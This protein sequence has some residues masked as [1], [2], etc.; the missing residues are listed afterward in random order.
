MFWDRSAQNEVNVD[1]QQDHERNDKR[2]FARLQD[3]PEKTKGIDA[4]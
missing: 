1:E 4:V 2:P 3:V